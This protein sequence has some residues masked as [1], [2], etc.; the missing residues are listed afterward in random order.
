VFCG[1][2]IKVNSTLSVAIQVLI[3]CGISALEKI[4]DK[5]ENDGEGES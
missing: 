5:D 3:E 2:A 4:A 1:D